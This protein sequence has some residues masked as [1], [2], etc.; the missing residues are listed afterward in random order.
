MCQ[1]AF[2]FSETIQNEDPSTVFNLTFSRENPY[3]PMKSYTD[4]L[5]KTPEEVNAEFQDFMNSLMGPFWAV[6]TLSGY[7]L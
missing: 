5:Q 6:F 4:S 1:K 2:R 7:T 3:Q